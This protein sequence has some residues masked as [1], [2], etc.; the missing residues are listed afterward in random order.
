MTSATETRKAEGGGITETR[1]SPFCTLRSV[2]L[3][4]VRWSRGFWHDRFEQ[5]RAVTLP[6]LDRLMSDPAQGHALTNLRIA[7]GLERG[8]FAGTHWQDEWVYKWLEAAAYVYDVTRD[9][10]LDRR[11]DEIIAVIARAQQPDGY[12]ATQIIVRGWPRFREIRHHELYVMGH[13]IT[14]ACIHHRVT[15]K[16]NFLD[17]AVKTADYLHDTFSPRPPALAHFDVNPSY[18]M[19]C[20]ELYRTVGDRRYL[21]LANVFIE[22]RGSQ[23]GGTDFNQDRV[24]LREETEVVGH[25]VMATYLYTGAA[26]A[27]MET[28]DRTLLEALDRLWRD[29]TGRKMYVHGGV[30][31]IHDGVSVRRDL[32]W[33]AADAAYVLPNSTAYNETCAQIG[34]MMWDWR[35]LGIT[36]ES[37]YTDQMEVLLHNSILSGIGLEGASWFYTNVL[38]WYGE[39]HPLLRNDAHARFQPGEPPARRHICCPSNL[40][41]TIAGLHGYAYSASDK[42]L[43]VNL[44]GANTFDGELPDG[45]RL[46]L[47]QET[48]YPWDGAIRFTMDAVSSS[49]F[50]LHLRI[51]RWAGGATLTVNGAPAG[52]PVEPGSYAT[53]DREWAAGDVAELALP[54]RVRLLESNPQ[55]EATRNQ[56]AVMRGPLV[57]CLESTD[58]PAGVRVQDVSIPRDVA[59]APR[60]VPG[61][62][63]GVTVL[64]GEAVARRGDDWTDALYREVSSVLPERVPITLIPYYAWHNRG[65]PEMTVWLPLG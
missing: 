33:E 3:G 5:C 43:W 54:M 62:L 29:L 31:P 44:Y 46:R 30:C 56:V 21:D 60:H 15:G 28:G 42:G 52:V 26:D 25:M 4:A 2:P 51:P 1:R 18:I 8:E 24:P 49:R 9:D 64:E 34:T 61:L 11:M 14:A 41:R 57:Y 37:I 7:A 35:M 6:H 65:E 59:F 48:D 20:V 58:L 63:G 32:V 16:R 23:P 47:T 40:L 17:V 39:D 36:G 50:A 45:T 38:R 53:L 22:M 10:V 27:Y 12:L 55:V 19:A 13:L